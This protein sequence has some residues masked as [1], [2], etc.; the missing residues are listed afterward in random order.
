MSSSSPK[1]WRLIGWDT[2][3]GAEYPLTDHD[4]E[5]KACEAAREKLRQVEIEQPSASSGGQGLLGIQDRVYIE[6]P[7]GTRYRFRVDT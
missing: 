4:S 3:E 5:D 6:R 7:D 1:R 2:F